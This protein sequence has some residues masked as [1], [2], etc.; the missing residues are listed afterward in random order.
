MFQIAVFSRFVFKPISFVFEV[1]TNFKYLNKLLI[2]EK[3][4]HRNGTTLKNVSRTSRV[5]GNSKMMFLR[6]TTPETRLK[7]QNRFFTG[8]KFENSPPS[9]APRDFT[10][11]LNK[12]K[13]VEKIVKSYRTK[14][15]QNRPR[16]LGKRRYDVV[17]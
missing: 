4:K 1:F 12:S 2:R 17:S 6:L 11:L 16:T 7:E 5:C 8:K 14:F 10:F 9:H 15:R 13:Y 3:F